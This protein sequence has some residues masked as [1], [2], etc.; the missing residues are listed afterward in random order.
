MKC[1]TSQERTELE[2]LIK[3]AKD[4][5]EW[6]RLFVILT[7][8]E[9][10]SIEELARFARLSPSTIEQYLKEYSSRNKTKNDPPWW[11]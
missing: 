4:V 8:D 10:M 2:L 11:Q 3:R 9:G 7:Y 5:S 6:K 1:L